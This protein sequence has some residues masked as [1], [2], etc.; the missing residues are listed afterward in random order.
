MARFDLE[1]LALL[2]EGGLLPVQADDEITRRGYGVRCPCLV[3]Y[4]DG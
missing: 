2:G 4:R 3:A 1:N